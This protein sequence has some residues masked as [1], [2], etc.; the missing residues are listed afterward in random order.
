[1]ASGQKTPIIRV[2]S[3]FVSNQAHSP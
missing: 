3:P 1:V 2:S